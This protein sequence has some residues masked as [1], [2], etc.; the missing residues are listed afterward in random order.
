ML[1]P[2]ERDFVDYWERNRLRRKKTFRQFLIGIPIGLLFAIPIAFNFV[3]GWDKQ[4]AMVFNSGG[5][6]LLLA[7]VLIVIFIAIFSQQHKWDQ[8]EQRYRE[9][10]VRQ[11]ETEEPKTQTAGTADGAAA[12]PGQLPK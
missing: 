5:G 1:T 11:S 2:E 4:A 12:T 6:A 10:L 9:L 3:S 7:L 8:Y